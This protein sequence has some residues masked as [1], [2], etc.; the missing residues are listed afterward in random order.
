MDRKSV[1]SGWPLVHL[2]NSFS[3]GTEKRSIW[4]AD[5]GVKCRAR[6]GRFRG[7]LHPEPGRPAPAPTL[8]GMLQ[9][10]CVPR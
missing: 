1:S 5:G 4:A 2:G 6:H 7:S 8:S 3:K 10:D 9:P